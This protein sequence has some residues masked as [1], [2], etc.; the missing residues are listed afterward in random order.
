MRRL[1]SVRLGADWLGAFAPSERRAESGCHPRL[2]LLLDGDDPAVEREPRRPHLP[3]PRRLYFYRHPD[4]PALQHCIRAQ[5]NACLQKL[6]PGT[7][8]LRALRSAESGLFV[9]QPELLLQA[10]VDVEPWAEKPA[11]ESPALTAR[12]LEV[13]RWATRG[14]SNKQI[15]RQL[16]ISPETVKTHLQHVFEREGVHNRITL[17]A[18]RLDS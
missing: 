7:S 4:V 9:V 6:A 14:L 17:L 5:A 8:V 2:L 1:L 10:L 3:P 15:A 18:R 13:V 11:G 16:Q 12:Q